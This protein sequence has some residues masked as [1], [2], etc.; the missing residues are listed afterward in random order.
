MTF[1]APVRD[2]LVVLPVLALSASASYMG[3]PTGPVVVADGSWFASRWPW[4]NSVQVDVNTFV[5][6]LDSVRYFLRSDTLFRQ[7]DRNDT[8]PYAVGID[9]LRIQ[10]LHPNGNWYDSTWGGNPANQIEKVRISLKVR[11]RQ[12]DNALA[13]NNPATRGYHYQTIVNEVAL[14]NSETLV[15]Q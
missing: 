10:Y 3:L 2:S 4:A 8:A 13:R 6:A 9:S 14:R 7:V 1:P 12:K 15:N 11:T 5:Y